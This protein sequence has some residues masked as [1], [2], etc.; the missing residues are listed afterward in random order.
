MLVNNAGILRDGQLAKYKDGDGGHR[1]D[2]RLGARVALPMPAA[3]P[4]TMTTLFRNPVSIMMTKKSPASGQW[5][6]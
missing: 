2:T 3:A 4:V 6:S 1:N 5:A